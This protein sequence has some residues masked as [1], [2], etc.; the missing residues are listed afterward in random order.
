MKILLTL[1][2]LLF[3]SS[4]FADDISDFQIE[5]ISV[6]NSALDY[7]SEK[8]IKK[9][10]KDTRFMYERLTEKFGEAY[11]YD[12]LQ[13]YAYMSLYV[14]TDDRKLKSWV[15][16]SVGAATSALDAM[17]IHMLSERCLITQGAN[18]FMLLN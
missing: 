6:G 14:K 10:I 17:Q 5:G 3:S 9:E 18:N 4:V 2:V 8:E 13:T 11:L 15:T 16:G 12:G 7:M 1:F